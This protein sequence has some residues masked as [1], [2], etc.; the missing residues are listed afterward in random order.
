MSNIYSKNYTDEGYL[1]K[2][3]QPSAREKRLNNQVYQFRI[4]LLN[5][6]PMIWRRIQ[7]PAY[8]NFWD[9]HVAIQDSMGW[10]DSH[11][12]HFEI[13]AAGKRKP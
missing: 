3:R 11:L 6:V 4:E 1:M 7:V 9:F 13:R 5:V 12:H 8:Y 2:Y 10:S